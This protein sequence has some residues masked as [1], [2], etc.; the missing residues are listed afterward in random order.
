MAV[1]ELL[2][3]LEH[4][5]KVPP[6]RPDEVLICYDLQNIE[7]KEEVKSRRAGL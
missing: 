4:A 5:G 6:S 1:A 7:V 3:W 2:L